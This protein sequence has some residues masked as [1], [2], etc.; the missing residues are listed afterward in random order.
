MLLFEFFDPVKQNKQDQVDWIGDLKFY[1]DQDE[2]CFVDLIYP[3]VVKHA[4][5]LGNPNAYKLYLKPIRRCIKRYSAVYNVRDLDIKFPT[6]D[7]EDL[8]RTIA[9]EQELYI[10]NGDYN[11]IA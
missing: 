11:E 3:A 6:P 8:A 5:H 4:K 10:K 1:I 7:L 2:E 9:S